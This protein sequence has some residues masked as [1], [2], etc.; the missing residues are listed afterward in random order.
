MTLSISKFQG[1]WPFQEK[2][3]YLYEK[4]WII[5]MY[6]IG[7]YDIII[8]NVWYG[9]KGPNLWVSKV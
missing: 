7:Q 2:Y 6:F 9:Q 4:I 3:M 8:C 1:H 5:Y